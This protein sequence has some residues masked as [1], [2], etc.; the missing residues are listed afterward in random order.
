M[1]ALAALTNS[2]NLPWQ[3]WNQQTMNKEEAQKFIVEKLSEFRNKGYYKLKELID[4]EPETGEMAGEGD[5][6]YQYEIQVFW[7]DKINGNIRVAGCI[8]D[9][10]WRVLYPLSDDFIVDRNNR[11]IGEEF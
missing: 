9:G 2:F 1:S 8:D 4:V 7:D 11:F 6:K 10:G 3:L 5:K